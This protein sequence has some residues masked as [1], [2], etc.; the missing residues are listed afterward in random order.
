MSEQQRVFTQQEARRL[1][2]FVEEI[3]SA[4][5][6]ETEPEPNYAHM[7]ARLGVEA[8][9]LLDK[10]DSQPRPVSQD[11]PEDMP[12]PLKSD[13][14]SEGLSACGLRQFAGYLRMF[15]GEGEL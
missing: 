7:V 10:I 11:V 6:K 5:W 1:L 13:R 3:A 14:W 8:Q 9:V 4:M 12:E 2:A 15:G